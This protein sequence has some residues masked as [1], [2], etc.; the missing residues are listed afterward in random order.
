M[1]GYLIATLLVLAPLP[2]AA[3][4][5]PAQSDTAWAFE[6]SD[7][8]LDRDF[9]FGRLGNGLRYVIRHNA[10]PAG[11]GIVRM[12]VEAG[13][14]DEAEQEQGF[15]HFVEHMAFNGSAR[16]PEGQMIPLL[17]R[18]GL[19]FGADTNASTGFD[20]TLYKLDLPRADPALLDTALML[21]RETASNL[22]ISQAAIDRERGVVLA[23]MRDRNSWS[24]RNTIGSTKFFYPGARYSERFPIGTTQTLNAATAATM[25]AFYEREYVPSHV[26][27]VIVGDFDVDEVEAG[28]VRHFNDWTGASEEPQPD[29]GP[30]L[31]K[32]RDRAEI[33]LDPALAERVTVQRNGKYRD[34]SDSIAQ[35]REGLL[36]SIGYDI[37][38]R[39]LQRLSRSA[40]P[41]F[42]GAGFGTGD[43]FE[44]GR[45]T[46]LIIDTVDGKWRAGLDAA[47]REYRRALTYGF[48]PGEVAEQVA[49]IRTAL[50]N[51]AGSAGTR[52]NA[53]LAQLAL[54]LVDDELVPSTP[55]SAR[56]RFE[57]FAPQIT[58]TAVLAAMKRE[59]VAL[60]KPLIRFQGRQAPDGG[61]A[62]LRDTWRKV[63]HAKIARETTS[64]ATQ[65]AYTDFGKPGEVVSDTRT[66][67]LGIREVRFA[68]GVMLNLRKTDLETDRV[69]V[70]L[71][72][73]GGDRLATRAN[74]LASEMTP[75]LDEG[76]L[77]LHSRDDLDSILAG[78]TVGFGLSRGASSFDS[79]VATTPRDL[80][81][82]LQLLTALVT[83]P[84]YRQEGEV[85]Y[86]QQINNYF[87]QARATPGSA[88]Q[89]DLGAILSDDDPRFSL[90]KVEDYRQLTYARLQKDIGD[91]LEHG[92]IEVGVVGDIDEDRTIALV[93][94]TLGALPAR[95][96]G[97]RDH[98]DQ[99]A[100]PFTN[101]RKPRVIRHTGPADQA[102]L[103][104]T[105]PTRDDS[106]PIETLALEMLERV[107]RVELT[108]Q[109]REA[110]G[111]AYSP[112]ASS[113]L[114][115]EWKGY[116]TFTVNASVEVSEVPATRAAIRQV[117]SELRSAPVSDDIL[118]RARQPLVEGLQNA[119]KSNGGWMALVDRAQ[120]Q[121]DQIERF[122]QAKGRLLALTPADVQAMATRYLAPDAGLEVL[123]LPEGVAAPK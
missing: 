26:T 5:R 76:G 52:S 69:R 50:A 44:A 45:S 88:L 36:R 8:P 75:Y 111:K 92:A 12:D 77:A 101:D 97:F 48:Q 90:Q 49:Q 6:H 89:A 118:R 113:Y 71:A 94:A 60:D 63:T 95:E 16:V 32:D 73:D 112:S 39:R 24:L 40:E 85:Q 70:S 19:A 110:L 7:V 31:P 11:T 109:L 35:R 56:D 105:W 43:V 104:I 17:E 115:H 65:F 21:M 108:D 114:S 66:P 55:Q 84:G 4:D 28:I 23:E 83:A 82:Q 62:A 9:R 2:L 74:P 38:N 59:A 30:I 57:A 86:R 14:L 51:A 41:P 122:E 58:S 10:T 78:R 20:R 29:A 1:R 117:V 106:D 120:T 53:A 91:R 116:G 119:L 42:R 15:A 96:P 98:D 37:V 68:N 102:L 79:Q 67:D 81:L 34:E 33:Y 123:V 87:A 22:T 103:R 121:P 61:E 64:A 107:M 18:E 72:I 13:S 54:S 100:R 47:G 46:R 25:R 27:L 3:K 99:P 80:E 93:A